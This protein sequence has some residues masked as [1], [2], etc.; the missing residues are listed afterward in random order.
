MAWVYIQNTTAA[1]PAAA[2]QRPQKHSHL[3]DLS[4]AKH[5]PVLCDLHGNICRC[6]WQR[7]SDR[8]RH[9]ILSRF[10]CSEYCALAFRPRC[11]IERK[12]VFCA[13]PKGFVGLTHRL[14]C[15]PLRQS[16]I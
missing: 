9:D 14:V 15:C 8:V 12:E 10:Y 3:S 2:E 13:L 4:L 1:L 7:C 5:L 16:H 6:V 11:S